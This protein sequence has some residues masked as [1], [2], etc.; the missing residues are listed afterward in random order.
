MD[1][2]EFFGGV[3]HGPTMNWLDFGGNPVHGLDPVIF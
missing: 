2:Y 3:W 1:F